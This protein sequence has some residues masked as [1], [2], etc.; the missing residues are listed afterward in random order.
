[1]NER[2]TKKTN[3]REIKQTVRS[4]SAERKKQQP[5]LTQKNRYGSNITLYRIHIFLF[6]FYHN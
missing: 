4:L 3:R 6:F 2:R 5:K 1:M